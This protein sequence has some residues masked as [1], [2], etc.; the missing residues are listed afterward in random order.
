METNIDKR[1]RLIKRLLIEE[2]LPEERQCLLKRESVEKEMQKQWKQFADEPIKSRIKKRIWQNIQHRCDGKSKTLVL[3]EL[4]HPLAAA[5]A[6]LLIIGGLLFLSVHDETGV[7]KNI[8]VIAEKNQLYVLPDSTKVWMQPGSS[9]RYAKAFMQDRRVW[10]EGSSL[11]E[12]RKQEG[13]T[14]QVYIYDAFIEVKGTCFLVKQEDAYRSEV[15]LFEGEVDFN[16]PSTRQKTAMLPLQKLTYNSIDSQTQLDTITNISW[17]NGRYN[18]KDVPLTQLIQIVSRMYHTDILVE[19][20]HRAEVSFS[21]S[22]HYNE[23]LDNVLNKIRFSL[24]LN[25]RKVDDRYILY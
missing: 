2:L 11:F 21:G 15:T 13:S 10:L 19:G 17:E 20:I 25:I 12:V 3:L 9:I 22:I 18:F 16:I 6:I 24:N 8:K 14:F 1:K 5:V 4:W 7:E 23:S